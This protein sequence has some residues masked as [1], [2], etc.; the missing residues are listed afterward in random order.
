MAAVATTAQVAAKE[1]LAPPADSSRASKASGE[2]VSNRD[3][4]QALCAA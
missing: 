4:A 3:K 1:A 2:A